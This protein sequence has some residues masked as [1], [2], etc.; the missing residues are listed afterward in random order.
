MQTNYE[1][2]GLFNALGQCVAK[3]IFVNAKPYQVN[4]NHLNNGLY[5]LKVV[6][7]GKAV[8]ASKFTIKH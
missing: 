8:S 5:L 3:E 4:T 2:R 7:N 6:E 1:E